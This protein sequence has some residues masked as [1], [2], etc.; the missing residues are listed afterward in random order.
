MTLLEKIKYYIDSLCIFDAERD[1][2]LMALRAL[3]ESAQGENTVFAYSEFFKS[4]ALN[5]TLKEH[6]SKFIMFDDNVFTRTA[7]FKKADSL[8]KS[9][10]EAVKL[11]LKKL[12]ELSNITPELIGSLLNMVELLDEMPGWELGEPLLPLKTNWE[13]QFDSLCGYYEENGCGKWA[14]YC[15]FSW[16]GGSLVPITMPSNIQLEDLKRY[17]RQRRQVVDNTKAFLLGLP[18]NNILLYG[19]R[20]T[21]KSSTVHAILNRYKNKGLRMIEIS[22]SDINDLT[23]I[24]EITGESPMKFIIFIDDLSF[25]SHEDSFG[26]LKAALEGSLSG[27]QKNC[28]IYATSNRRHLIKESFLDRE[29]DV[30]RSDTMQE[31]LSLSDRFG[32][33]I[34]F[35]N[36]DRDEYFDILDKIAEDRGLSVDSVLLMEKAELWARRRGGR[37]PRCAKQFIDY[38]EACEKQDLPW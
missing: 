1:R 35:E 32:L 19:D 28:L 21:G 10:I 20:G 13:N 4:F 5:E 24:R 3:T 33:S 17:D 34:Y 36:P 11:D 14:E 18:S 9:V 27:K 8:S 16:R 23:L 12:E 7:A 25:D 26:E 2:T 37:S 30:H 38:V 6:I 29:N 31:E 15:A 22:K